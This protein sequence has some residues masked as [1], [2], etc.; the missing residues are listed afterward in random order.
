MSSNSPAAV[1]PVLNRWV[2]GL[3]ILIPSLV[4]LV[5]FVWLAD[6][7]SQWQQLAYGIGKTA[8]FALPV[9]WVTLAQR[10]PIRWRGPSR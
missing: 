2:V 6:G 8:Q 3:A 1:P 9:A 4:T 10:Q 5:Y 7:G